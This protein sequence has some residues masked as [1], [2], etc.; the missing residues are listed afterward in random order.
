M[1]QDKKNLEKRLEI[2]QRCLY[3]LEEQAA[4]FGYLHI[5]P[6]KKIELEEKRKEVAEIK[7]ELEKLG[8][9]IPS[10]EIKYV[11]GMDLGDGESSISFAPLEQPKEPPPPICNRFWRNQYYYCLCNPRRKTHL[12]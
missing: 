11:V 5:E 4:G 8:Y 6:S 3:A 9:S 7:R 1:E 10:G 12:R 2:A